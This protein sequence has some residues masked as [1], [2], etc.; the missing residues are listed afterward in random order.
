MFVLI[1]HKLP[2]WSNS[3][4]RHERMQI[5]INTLYTFCRKIAVTLGVIDHNYSPDNHHIVVNIP[6]KEKLWV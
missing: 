3:N 5:I 4:K 2:K 6:P 1:R